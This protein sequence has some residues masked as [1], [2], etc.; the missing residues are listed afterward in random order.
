M[1]IEIVEQLSYG[2]GAIESTIEFENKVNRQLSEF[3]ELEIEV[4]GVDFVVENNKLKALIKIN[5]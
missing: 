5:K 3:K 4:I 2:A 1:Q